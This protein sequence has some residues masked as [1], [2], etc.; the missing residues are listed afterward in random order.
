MGVLSPLIHRAEQFFNWQP[1]PPTK[2]LTK[3]QI[4]DTVKTVQELDA[5][6]DGR[7]SDAMFKFAKLPKDECCR[8]IDMWMHV[9]DVMKDLPE[10]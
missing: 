4:K 2:P 7:V 9:M 8:L 1:G 10:D 6:H 3:R 5:V